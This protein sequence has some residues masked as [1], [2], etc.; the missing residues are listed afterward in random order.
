M[1]KSPNLLPCPF[2]GGEAT[3]V[4]RSMG[5]TPRCT[6]LDCPAAFINL[7]YPTIEEAILAWNRRAGDTNDD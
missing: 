4:D 6:N 1:K 2:C 5:F 3:V 7:Y